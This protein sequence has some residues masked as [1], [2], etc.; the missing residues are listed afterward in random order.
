MTA[1]LVRRVGQHRAGEIEGFSKVYG[2]RM[3]VYFERHERIEG[4]IRR[5]SAIKKWPRRWK[6]Q[7]ITKDDY[8]WVYLYDGIV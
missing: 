6:V 4:A 8:G 3:L 2:V 5:E 1:D 7:S